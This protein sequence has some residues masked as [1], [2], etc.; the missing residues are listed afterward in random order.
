MFFLHELNRTIT[1]H[2]SYFDA[3]AE[4]TIKAKLL[5]DV[6]GTNTGEYYVVCVVDMT[7]VSEARVLP[8]TAFAEYT[9]HYRAVVWRP[10]RGEVTDGSVSA[11]V[12][13]G[14]FVEVGPLNVFVSKAMIPP[15]IR[16]DANATPPQWT[17]GG[18]QVVERGTQVRLRIKGIRGEVGQMYAIG[19]IREDY[20]G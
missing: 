13:N 17:D 1:L 6:E 3:Q 12:P 10:F 16:Y 2:P 15:E 20:L 19:T 8:G 11:V 18:E 4:S 14:F 9:V 7:D 5:Q